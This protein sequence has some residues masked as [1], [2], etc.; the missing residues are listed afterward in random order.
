M[1]VTER[2]FLSAFDWPLL[3]LALALLL[4]GLANLY[5]AT[6]PGVAGGGLPPDFA[7]QLLALC[8]ALTAFGVALLVD[9]RHFERWAPLL[10]GLSLLLVLSTLVF[11]PVI[12]GSR[13]WLIMGSLSLQPAEFA[14]LGLVLMLAR[15]FQRRPPTAMRGL[16]DMLVP[17]LIL[18]APVLAVLLQRDLG[19]AVL[20]LLTGGTYLL[21]VR[22]PTRSWLMMAGIV[23]LGLTGLWNYVFR[24]YQRERILDFIDPSR[25]P[26]ASGYQAIQSH[27]AVG[28]G[29]LFGQGYLQ[30]PQ[31][32]LKFLPTQHS[33][34]AFSV[35]AEEWGF[36][37]CMVLLGVYSAILLRGLTVAGGAKDGFGM[38]LAIG[39]VGVLFWPALINVAVV[40]GLAPV[41]GLPFPLVSAGGSQLLVNLVA[42]GLLMNISMRR[43]LF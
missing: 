1:Q 32:Q 17:G 10:Y 42:L 37:G 6:R 35:L 43:Y 41:I 12:R 26:L 39:L 7:R 30:G 15:Y 29:G 8:V 9:Y 11:A 3:L 22:M 23:L 40:L 4:M 34:F 27:I 19:V 36:A 28:S 38:M 20:I 33:D 2:R 24:E 5:S 21:F 18:A 16:R 31:T 25:D 13:S 14:K